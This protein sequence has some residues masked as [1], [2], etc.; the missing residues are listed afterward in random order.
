MICPQCAQEGERSKVWAGASMGT[1]IYCQP[2]YDEDGVYHRHDPNTTTISY[3]CS[4]GHTWTKRTGKGCPNCS[5]PNDQ[6][7]DE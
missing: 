6:G 3:H 1:A 2:Y 4:R 7:E 5:W